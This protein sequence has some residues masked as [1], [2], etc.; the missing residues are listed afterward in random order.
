MEHIKKYWWVYLG[1]IAL[2]IILFNVFAKKP[3]SLYN[4]FMSQS[5][6]PKLVN[7]KCPSGYMPQPIPCF[8]AP[9]PPD[10]CVKKVSLVSNKK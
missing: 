1:G 7:G 9:C 10:I 6:N 5:N 4:D 8:V 2:I 3:K